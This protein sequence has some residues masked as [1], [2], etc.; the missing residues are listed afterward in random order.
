MIGLLQPDCTVATPNKKPALG[1]FFSFHQR[2]LIKY[3]F[4]SGA[5]RR[6]L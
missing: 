3:G 4:D 5:D 6:L 1:R 2:M